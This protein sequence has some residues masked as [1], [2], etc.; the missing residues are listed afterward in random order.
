MNRMTLLFCLCCLGPGFF[1]SV[2]AS[3]AAGPSWLIPQGQVNLLAAGRTTAGLSSEMPVPQ[4]LFQVRGGPCLIHNSQY[5]IIAQERSVLSLDDRSSG[6][7]LYVKQGRLSFTLNE[8]AWPVQVSTPLECFLLQSP[9][10]MAERP[11]GLIRGRL[12]VTESDVALSVESGALD[13]HT[14]SGRHSV[15]AGQSIRLAQAQMTPEGVLESEE[16]A[17][18][19]VVPEEELEAGMSGNTKLILGGVGAVGV[20]A[21]IAALAGGGGGGGGGGDNGGDAGGGGGGGDSDDGGG[22]DDGGDNGQVSPQ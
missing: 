9:A 3:L 12:S 8:R 19:E 16:E 17:A 13:L 2:S 21:G 18:D 15:L 14:S 6:F 11:S 10:D 4:E 5:Q 1:G 20:A 7:D 22:D